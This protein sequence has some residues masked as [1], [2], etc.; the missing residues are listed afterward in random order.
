MTDSIMQ[1]FPP[2][3]HAQVTLAN[4]RTSPYSQWAFHHVREIIPSAAIRHRPDNI[5][6]LEES[7]VNLGGLTI[8]C[9]NME[10]MSLAGF[11]SYANVDAMIILHR[12]KIVFEHYRHG[13]NQYDPHI[14]MSV[15]KSLLGLLCGILIH[16]GRLDPEQQA[17]FYVPELKN[18]AYKNTTVRQLL[19]MRAGVDFTEDYEAD[20]GL[21]IEYRKASGWNPPADNESAGDLRSFYQKMTSSKGPDG[22]SFFYV[23]PNTD[24]LAWIIERA[25]NT[26]YAELL[27]EHLWQPMG[28]ESDAYIT[29]DRLGA[30]RA[31]GGVCT[32]LRDLA[33]VARLVAHNGK[34]NDQQILAPGWVDDVTT[35]GDKKGWNDG[36]FVAYFP[37]LPFSYRNQWYVCHANPIDEAQWLIAL[38]IHGQNI[39]I[40]ADNEFVMVKFSSDPL[41]LCDT[42]GMHGLNAARTI[43]DYLVN[44][45]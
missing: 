36:D 21:I 42:G 37:D 39:Y 9:D 12:D 40:D 13:M 3:S 30:P 16:R 45:F 32:T 11:I 5:W 28:A 31:A 1:A 2:A 10:V 20:S 38:G 19:D 26:A 6:A 24:L 18:T 43:R 14:L 15:S 25:C 29:V 35:N 27:S 33:R 23:S 34:R 7:P 17:A 44:H 41:A 4:W 22:G 8:D